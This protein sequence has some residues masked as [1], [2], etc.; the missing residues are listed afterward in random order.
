MASL[1]ANNLTNVFV[2]PTATVALAAQDRI[3]VSA[4]VPLGTTAW[5]GT[6]DFAH[7]ICYQVNGAG[8]VN[9][10]SDQISQVGGLQTPFNS[11]HM[12][13]LMPG[14]YKIG[15]CVRNFGSAI[16]DKIGRVN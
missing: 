5:L 4:G 12:P 16:L 9:A 13:D 7:G 3:F 1:A 11:S 15:F 6:A 10:L 2:G 14:T 8:A